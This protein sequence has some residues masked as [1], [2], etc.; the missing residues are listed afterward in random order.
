MAGLWESVGHFHPVLIHFPIALVF[1]ALAAE[2]LLVL[3]KEAR[4]G[5]AARFSVT[6]A[7]WISI[8]VAIAG[9]ALASGT[10]FTEEEMGTF[11]IHR[12]AGIITPV[13]IFLAAGMDA[14]ARRSGQVWELFLYRVFLVLAAVSVAVAGAH[15]GKLVW[16]D[17]YFGF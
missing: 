2:F 3:K 1:V 6:A 14:S 4:F 8:P 12:I 7:A 13:L 10:T 16:G 15:G 17:G 9:F 5:E 11:A